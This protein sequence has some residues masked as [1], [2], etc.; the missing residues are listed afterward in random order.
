MTQ[1]T[2]EMIIQ[3]L[4]KS[5][6]FMKL[7][8]I[9]FVAIFLIYGIV[10]FFKFK[11]EKNYGKGKDIIIFVFILAALIGI[12]IFNGSLKYSA[13]QYSIKNNCFEVITD[14]VVR[15]KISKDNDGDSTYYVYL[16]NNG[17]I[18]VSRNTYY[19]CSDGES[20]YVVIA[21]GRFGRKYQTGQLYSTINYQYVDDK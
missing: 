2:N 9:G 12:P 16:T 4:N 13:I 19:D 17:K 8:L 5:S 1:L 14:T 20:V 7:E 18:N 11:K 10:Y 15:K 21:K 6:P 3:S